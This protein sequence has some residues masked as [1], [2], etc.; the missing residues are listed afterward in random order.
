[1]IKKLIILSLL[2]I[3][4]IDCYA[5]SI[6]FD[7]SKPVTVKNV[8]SA[9]QSKIDINNGVG[10]NTTINNGSLVG[11]DVS[12]ATIITNAQAKSRSLSSK[13]NDTIDVRD[14]GA[15]CDVNSSS[16]PTDDTTAIQTAIN[17]AAG[18][19][20]VKVFLPGMCEV[21]STITATIP[22]HIKIEGGGLY[23]NGTST[24]DGLDL[25][26]SGVGK[27]DIENVRFKPGPN[28]A[29][30]PLSII[31]NGGDIEDN[32]DFINNVTVTT[33]TE[34]IRGIGFTTGIYLYGLV[35][36]INNLS[37]TFPQ[38]LEVNNKDTLIT[39]SSQDSGVGLTFAG[40]PSGA[41]SVL[42]G[43]GSL[44]TNM[45]GN[46]GFAD[47]RF[48]GMSQ[49]GIFTNI[50][51]NWQTHIVYAGT[52]VVSPQSFTFINTASQTG[53]WSASDATLFDFEVKGGQYIINNGIYAGSSG[54]GNWTILKCHGCT[55]IQFTNNQVNQNYPSSAP[56]IDTGS[57]GDNGT[58]WV[59]QNNTFNAPNTFASLDSTTDTLNFAGLTSASELTFTGNKIGLIAP[60][61]PP[62]LKTGSGGNI[63]NSSGNTWN[64]IIRKA[65]TKSLSEHPFIQGMLS[66][67]WTIDT[68]VHGSGSVAANSYISLTIDGN[69]DSTSNSLATLRP[70]NTVGNVS[71]YD[72]E[73]S[74]YEWGNNPAK[75]YALF[76]V[77]GM[78]AVTPGGTD[79][80]TLLGQSS[81]TQ[82]SLF[83]G[84]GE[85][86]TGRFVLSSTS[87]S[88]TLQVVNVGTA[89]STL[90]CSAIIHITNIQ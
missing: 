2:L 45:Q 88:P 32:S 82:S 9:F 75:Y 77:V 47:I 14:Y 62:P 60:I 40:T 16:T 31:G 71:S 86:Y 6:G 22:N 36:Y 42:N 87:N 23:V 73:V 67:D 84:S 58:A 63:I 52:D 46:G 26:M 81:T 66:P 51:S 55:A 24:T 64:S 1:M 78:F 61:I 5:Q 43:G 41:T 44:V 25:T 54:A 53:F 72:A 37:V 65:G 59:I 19:D 7:I 21:T 89:T 11:T 13:F 79:T 83:S 70:Y 48:T 34:T 29:G 4:P 68:K 28:G 69:A 85:S 80:Y 90:T 56:L 39:Y 15:K 49:G 3:K 17:V 33:S 8:N 50:V 76:H 10:N 74:C 38:I 27:F 57:S 12:T 18:M 20:Y 35:A 30:R